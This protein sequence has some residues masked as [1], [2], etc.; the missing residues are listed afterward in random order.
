MESHRVVLG[1][2]VVG[3]VFAA[4]LLGKPSITGFVPT[5]TYSQE[6][7]IEVS[8]S[9]RFILTA[10][11]H[12][13][14]KLS[15]L[16]ISGNVQGPGLVN[17]YLSDGSRRWLLFS[18]KKKPGSDMEVITGLAVRELEIEPGSKIDKIETLPAGYKAAPGAF[19]DQCAET[20]VLDES[21]F[22]SEQLYLDVVIE[23]GTTVH[24][25]SLRFS[26]PGE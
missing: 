11:S 3:I 24:I 9:Q 6:L 14:L 22:T 15:S 13:V 16:G 4:L 18:N 25:S 5:E 2:I 26:T 23:P 10:S 19:K 17:V 7:N 12:D 20:C 1:L 21:A 8:D